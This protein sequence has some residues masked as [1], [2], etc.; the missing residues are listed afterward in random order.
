MAGGPGKSLRTRRWR[1]SAIM[2][3]RAWVGV[4]RRPPEDCGGETREGL[5]KQTNMGRM[6][7]GVVLDIE[8]GPMVYMLCPRVNETFTLTSIVNVISLPS[9]HLHG[10]VVDL[11]LPVAAHDALLPVP[12][13]P[14]GRARPLEAGQGVVGNARVRAMH[15]L[16][17]LGGRSCGHGKRQGPQVAQTLEREEAWSMAEERAYARHPQP[18]LQHRH[19]HL[20]GPRRAAW[21]LPRGAAAQS[22]GRPGQAG[23]P[24]GVGRWRGAN[25]PRPP[26]PQPAPPLAPRPSTAPAVLATPPASSAAPADPPPAASIAD[27]PAP[28]V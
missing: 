13:P 1:L 3:R 26:R 4:A 23:A 24:R 17:G 11:P 14:A 5:L 15:H 20:P 16:A 21:A 22:R 2:L 19:P 28:R 9:P 18:R 8:H 12:A 10:H 25:A 6:C 27:A 7:V